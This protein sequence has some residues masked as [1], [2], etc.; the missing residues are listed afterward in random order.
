MSIDWSLCL[1][2]LLRF[3]ALQRL[4]HL[5]ILPPFICCEL[6]L[7]LVAFLFFFLNPLI[8]SFTTTVASVKVVSV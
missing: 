4:I 2:E 8:R 7:P 5:N 3:E 1:S 6:N